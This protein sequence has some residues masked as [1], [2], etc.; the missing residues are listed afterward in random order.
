LVRDRCWVCEESVD[1]HERDQCGKDCQ[2]GVEGNACAEQGNIVSLGLFPAAFGYL[3]PAAWRNFGGFLG[4]TTW[5]I[6]F[7]LLVLRG[8]DDL[9]PSPSNA[10]LPAAW[11]SSPLR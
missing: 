2:E 3:E 5:Y 1:R 10:R 7:A 6:D 4:V 8:R 9:S 11:T